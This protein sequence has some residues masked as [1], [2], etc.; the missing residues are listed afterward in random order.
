MLNASYRFNWQ[1]HD[2]MD[3]GKLEINAENDLILNEHVDECIFKYAKSPMLLHTMFSGPRG[4]GKLFHAFKLLA[5]HMNV[6]FSQIVR[7]KKRLHEVDD[8]TFPFLQ[9]QYHFEIDVAHFNASFNS[10]K[11]IV[12][13]IN[14][15]AKS[16]NVANNKHNIIFIKNADLLLVRI[17]YQLRRLMEDMYSTARL[18]LFVKCVARIDDTIC[19]R[20]LR[21]K[22]RYLPVAVVNDIIRKVYSPLSSVPVETTNGSLQVLKADNT[23]TTTTTTT[24]IH[25]TSNFHSALLHVDYE[26][27]NIPQQSVAEH[28]AKSLIQTLRQSSD[29]LQS[30][31][32]RRNILRDMNLFGSQITYNILVNVINETIHSFVSSSGFSSPLQSS[33]TLQYFGLS[34]LVSD[35]NAKMRMF[36]TCDKAEEIL[37]LIFANLYQFWQTVIVVHSQ[38]LTQL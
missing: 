8:K 28:Y 10:Q 29:P 15:F 35:T 1:T 3:N 19:S 24:T 32:Q 13:M 16:K 9:S 38:D 37:E 27:N 30:A 4:C 25:T 33:L 6:S 2:D 20:C 18:F 31:K 34:E 21:I 26:R 12:D 7:R 17:Q 5:C 11:I 14:E 22:I 36:E 23:T